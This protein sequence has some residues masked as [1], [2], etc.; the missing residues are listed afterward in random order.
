MN[1][2]IEELTPRCYIEDEALYSHH[3]K[4]Y[5]VAKPINLVWQKYLSLPPEVVWTGK[6][7]KFKEL[8]DRSKNRK[9]RPG[10]IYSDPMV[11]GQLILLELKIF[12]GLINVTVGHEVMEINENQRIIKTSYLSNSKSEGSQFIR[13]KDLANGTTQVSH[14]TFY[15]SDSWFRDR[16]IY[17]FFHTKALNEFHNNVIKQILKA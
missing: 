12:N 10:E 1:T 9:V 13:F 3:L 17:P 6:M 8:Y 14:E 5:L 2:Q 4:T 7:I 11:I 16:Y 15:K